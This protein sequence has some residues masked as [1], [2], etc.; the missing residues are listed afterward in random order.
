MDSI[1]E[2]ISR[3]K[4]IGKINKGE[5]INSKYLFVQSDD[6]FT[7][8]SRTFYYKDNRVNTL[9]FIK[10][11]ARESLELVRRLASSEK[12]SDKEMA[13]NVL[14]DLKLSRQGIINIRDTYSD[15]IKFG[16]DV[17][18]LV[19][20]VDVCLKEIEENGKKMEYS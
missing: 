1:N 18:T 2:T 13:K 16:C 14:H 9:S 5:K 12:T 10:E 15:D 8:I 20:V 19:Q 6:I 7:K 4:F 11:T 3:L 17:D